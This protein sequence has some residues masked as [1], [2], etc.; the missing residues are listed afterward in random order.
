MQKGI[1][2]HNDIFFG[3]IFPEVIGLDYFMLN[4]RNFP[5]PTDFILFLNVGINQPHITFHLY[6]INWTL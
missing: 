5:I 4:F 2:N 3:Y 1:I 6:E